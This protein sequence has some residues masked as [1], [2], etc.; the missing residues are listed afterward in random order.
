MTPAQPSPWMTAEEAVAYLR[1]PSRM[2]LYQAVQRGQVPVHRR[3]KR[4]LFHREEIDRAL[5]K[6]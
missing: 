6:R 4:L 1:Y 5:L 2:A 3:G